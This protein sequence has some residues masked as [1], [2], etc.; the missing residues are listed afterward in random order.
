VLRHRLVGVQP[1]AERARKWPP[2]LI[3]HRTRAFDSGS[4]GSWRLG[5]RGGS[6]YSDVLYVEQLITPDAVNTMPVATLEAFD[7]HG[8]AHATR[9]DPVAAEQTLESA[10]AAGA[11]LDAITTILE[12]EGVQSFQDSYDQLVSCINH[13]LGTLIPSAP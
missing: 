8:D 10:R 3:H 4:G 9:L 11:D 5:R 2:R 13:K 6:D 7:D 1:A 12:T